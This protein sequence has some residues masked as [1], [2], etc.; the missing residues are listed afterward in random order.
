MSFDNKYF[1]SNT[2][3][4]VSFAKYS[5]YWWSNRFYATLARRYSQPGARLLEI[6]SGLGHLAG[7]LENMFETYAADVNHWA[8]IQSKSIALRTSLQEA[9][10]EEL[11]FSEGAFGVVIIKHVLEHLPHP[12]KAILELGRIIVPGGVL[13]FATPNLSSLL[14]PCKGKKWIGYQDPTH[15]SLKP[16]AEWLDMIRNADFSLQKVFSDG[17]WDV[18]YIPLVPKVLQ[19]LVFGFLGGFQAIIGLPFLPMRWG[20]SIMVVARKLTTDKLN[21]F[22]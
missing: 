6:G 16:P 11:P 9:S 4:N 7:Q 1:Y 2:Y 12:E 8:L 18:P 3:K 21:E 10:A 15:I 17:F 13:I 22:K 20:E 14:K 19:K 5:Q